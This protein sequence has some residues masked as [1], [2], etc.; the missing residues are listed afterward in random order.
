VTKLTVYHLTKGE[1]MK[2]R[3][4]LIFTVLF[5]LI[6]SGCGAG[7]QGHKRVRAKLVDEIKYFNFGEN[8]L[9]SISIV[10]EIQTKYQSVDLAT[11]LA[12]LVKKRID[13]RGINAENTYT[14]MRDDDQ[15]LNKQLDYQKQSGRKIVYFIEL[16]N[17]ENKPSK[18][19]IV[20]LSFVIDAINNKELFKNCFSTKPK[21]P[22]GIYIDLPEPSETPE[23]LYSSIQEALTPSVDEALDYY[24]GPFI[25]GC[26]TNP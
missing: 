10:E 3:T 7:I 13:S 15:S 5:S 11:M 23:V 25:A 17:E 9:L 12:D 22:I 26:K 18:V 20:S 19:R 2:T 14:K 6:V 1:I 21:F 24:L 16:Q 8:T 4:F